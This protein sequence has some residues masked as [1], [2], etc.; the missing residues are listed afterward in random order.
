MQA[1]VLMHARTQAL[2]FERATLLSDMAK[3]DRAMDALLVI[4]AQHPSDLNV[5]SLVP[6][7]PAYRAAVCT[8]EDVH[9]LALVLTVL[10]QLLRQIHTV[11]H[12]GFPVNSEKRRNKAAMCAVLLI[13]RCAALGQSR[14]RWP[15][16][17]KN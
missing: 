12:R 9:F 1:P 6:G 7:R 2:E 17:K 10:C 14:Q 13:D 5:S 4:L 16:L 11:L 3:Y 15:A 8:D